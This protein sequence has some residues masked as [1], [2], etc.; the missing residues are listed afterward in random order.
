MRLRNQ[1]ANFI[2]ALMLS[3]IAVAI[4]RCQGQEKPEQPA[5]N[6]SVDLELTGTMSDIVSNAL[7]LGFEKDES[8]VAAYLGASKKDFRLAGKVRGGHEFA[9]AAAKE[10]DIKEE[11][12]FAAIEEYRHCNCRHEGGDAVGTEKASMEKSNGKVS[13]FAENVLVHVVLH[14]IGHGLV[15]EFDLPILGNEETLADS[16]ATY[17]IATH[18]PERGMEILE[19]R[20]S[21]LMIEAREVPRAQWTV[22]GEHNSDARRAYQIVAIAMAIDASKFAPLASL[23]DMNQSDIRKAVD[24]G[25]EIQRSWRR[26]LK[27]LWMSGGQKSNEARTIIEEQ[28]EFAEAI[29]GGKLHREIDDAL[30]S[31]DWHSQVK[32][33]FASG[34]GGAGWSRSKRTVTV[35]DGYVRRFNQQSS[36]KSIN[37]DKN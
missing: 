7:I 16:F 29:S 2:L 30:K 18:M 15:R 21:S 20:V 33:V 11:T 24:Y 25:S 12:L 34:D 37:Q 4:P 1:K 13:E 35:Q 26:I 23:V 17:Y 5:V 22:K 28:S 6:C 27:P 19:A 9:I 3:V 31:F 10:F 32:V 36:L 8:K 14:E